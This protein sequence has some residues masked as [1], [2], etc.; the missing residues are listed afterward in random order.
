VL[1]GARGVQHWL[2]VSIS[3]VPPLLPPFHVFT[4]VTPPQGP[5]FVAALGGAC[6]LERASQPR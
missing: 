4:N 3:A 2:C 1:C 5:D 6:E